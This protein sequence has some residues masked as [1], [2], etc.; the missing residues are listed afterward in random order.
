MLG[1]GC[2]PVLFDCP[3]RNCWFD[4]DPVTRFDDAPNAMVGAVPNPE[5]DVPKSGEGVV[6]VEN[7][8]PPVLVPKPV[9]E[10]V[11]VLPVEVPKLA[12][13]AGEVPKVVDVPNPAPGVV[14][15]KPPILDVPNPPLGVPNSPVVLPPKPPVDDGGAF[16]N[17]MD[18]PKPPPAL[19]PKPPVDVVDAFP[20]DVDVPNPPPVLLPPKPPID[21]T[22]AV[23]KAVDDP[24]PPPLPAFVLA[25]P[26]VVA[27]VD[28]LPNVIGVPKPALLVPPKLVE[29]DA[30]PNVVL[31][32]V[33][34]PLPAPNPPVDVAGVV[35][36]VAVVPKPPAELAPKP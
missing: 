7:M 31:V 27:V 9:A 20:K 29:I 36:K 2:H 14:P 6:A 17:V 35:P 32:D 25:K 19:V 12:R 15:P 33:P 13:P 11:V 23:P 28:A 34:N 30:L 5:D 4:E 26:P 24:N 21:V 22:E 16:P 18:V 3:N 1:L 8:P 10:L